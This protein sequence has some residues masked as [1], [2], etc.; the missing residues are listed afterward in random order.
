M[1]PFAIAS[2][3]IKELLRVMHHYQQGSPL[4]VL[5]YLGDQ[6]APGLLSFAKPGVTL[7]IDMADRG[8]ITKTLYKKLCTLIKQ[9]RGRIYPAKDAL[10]DPDF[11]LDYFPRFSDYYHFIDPYFNSNL[12]Q[13]FKQT[14]GEKK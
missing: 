6:P 8:E 10:L 13:R 1:I 3:T 11:V 2:V 14:L 7:A 5:K 4:G 9:A 12:L